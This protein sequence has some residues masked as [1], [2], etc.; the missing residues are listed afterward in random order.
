[1]DPATFKSRFV[2]AHGNIPE[3][4]DFDPSEFVIFELDALLQVPLPAADAKFLSE[5]GL[6]ASAA[7]MLDFYAWSADEVASMR[8]TYGIPGDFFPIGQTNSGDQICVGGPRG[9]VL[10]FEHDVAP[11]PSVFINS[12]LLLFAESLCVYQQLFVERRHAEVAEALRR[13]D[14]PAMLP[15][16]MWYA[17]SQIPPADNSR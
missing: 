6:P 15:G 16:A 7:P 1:M 17:D 10:Y 12:S 13:I 14:P 5:I 2:A 9:A 8:V 4:A 11:P 3:W